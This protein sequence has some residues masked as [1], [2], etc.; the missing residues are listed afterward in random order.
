MAKYICNK[1]V[2]VSYFAQNILLGC[3]HNGTTEHICR[4]YSSI[5]H[6]LSYLWKG[7]QICPIISILS[8][9]RG[10]SGVS[11]FV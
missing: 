1:W 8:D 4:G 7:A 2:P 3:N 9:D 5:A 6:K 11:Y 10:A